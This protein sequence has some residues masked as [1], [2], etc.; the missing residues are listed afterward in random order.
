MTP[1]RRSILADAF[2]DPDDDP[3]TYMVRSSNPDPVKVTRTGSMLTLTPKVLGVVVLTVRAVDSH[4]LSATWTLSV[5]V[6]MGTRDYD[7]DDDNLID[8]GNLEQLD[9]I[10]YDLNG[11]GMV[12]DASDLRSYYSALAFAEGAL[13]MGCSSGCTG[14]ELTTSLDFD[15]NGSGSADAGDDYWNGGAGWAPIGGDGTEMIGTFLVL[16]NRFNAIFEGNGHTVSN[17]FIDTDTRLVAGLFGYA[18]SDIRNV[19]L[20]DVDVT[21][22]ELAAGLAAANA[23]EISASYVTGSVSGAENVGGLVGLSRSQGG[24]RGS[25]ATS[26]V[27]GEDDVG[28][29]VG[30]NRGQ[31]TASYATGSVSG[32]SSVGGLVGDNR[33]TGEIRGSYATSPVSGDSDVGGLVGLNAGDITASYWDTS[34]SGHTTGSSGEGKTTAQ[35]QTPTGFSGIYQSWNADLWHFGTA[36]QFPALKANVDGQGQASVAGVRPPACGKAPP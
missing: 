11:D 33:P 25:Y 18:G 16:H 10:R 26:S 17:L 3:L 13:D 36:S 15:T 4:G 22:A 28:G 12:D 32:T 7:L 35:L 27:S 2:D 31:I 23:G 14:Y 20:I 19:G 1:P 9:A 29:L 24:I 8:V 6:A 34:T 30:D 21:G 5:T